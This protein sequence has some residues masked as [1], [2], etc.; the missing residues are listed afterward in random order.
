MAWDEQGNL[1]VADAFTSSVGK[2]PA[3]K[4]PALSPGDFTFLNKVGPGSDN[5]DGAIYIGGSLFVTQPFLR[6]IAEISKTDGSI[7]RT[8]PTPTGVGDLHIDPLSGDVFGSSANGL[9]RIKNI[10]TASPT[11]TW[12]ITISGAGVDGHTFGP[13][14]TI[15]LV[16]LNRQAVIKVDGT[17]VNVG[18]PTWSVFFTG[19]P[20]PDGAAVATCQG[21]Q[22]LIVDSETSGEVKAV[23]LNNP[24]GAFT[25]LSG[26]TSKLDLANVGPDGAFYVTQH[27][28]PVHNPAIRLWRL[29]NPDC[30][31]TK[32]PTNPPTPSAC[33]AC[34]SVHTVNSNCLAASK[35]SAANCVALSF[36]DTVGA[37][38][39]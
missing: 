29:T 27:Y 30:T 1:Y 28:D 38:Q 10:N 11:V 7:I 31:F 17:N 18:A 33:P 24:A 21:Q 36:A 39:C 22:Y 25:I 8:F 32:P 13:D 37:G 35:T 12:Y 6:V 9:V 26:A 19:I 16:D 14:G 5:C 15:Y 3:S 23:P 20:T 2:I 34:S 4:L